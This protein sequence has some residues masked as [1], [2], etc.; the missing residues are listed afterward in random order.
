MLSE[1]PYWKTRPFLL[2]W[3]PFWA[4][5]NF[6]EGNPLKGS[7]NSSFL[8]DSTYSFSKK[9]EIEQEVYCDFENCRKTASITL[10]IPLQASKV[11][12]LFCQKSH[13]TLGTEISQQKQGESEWLNLKLDVKSYAQCDAE[14]IRQVFCWAWCPTG[15]RFVANR[16][17]FYFLG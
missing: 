6:S 14:N 17:T 15:Q 5:W 2:K 12:G 7:F 3:S 11:Q 10:L 4:T 8:K 1:I 13:A 16:R 9:E